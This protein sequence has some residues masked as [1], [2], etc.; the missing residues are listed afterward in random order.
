ME[1]TTSKRGKRKGFG[2]PQYRNGADSTNRR[3][4]GNGD[5]NS[6]HSK[7]RRSHGV[8]GGTQ[9]TNGR[10][11]RSRDR[12]QKWRTR[13]DRHNGS[14]Q[15]E[16]QQLSL[17]TELSVPGPAASPSIPG[18]YFDPDKGKYFKLR[19]GEK[20][21]FLKMMSD[22]AAA[23]ELETKATNPGTPLQASRRQIGIG[24][25]WPDYACGNLV[26]A[27][28]GRGLGLV[29]PLQMQRSAVT[30]CLWQHRTSVKLDC[31]RPT[32]QVTAIA[33]NASRTKLAMVLSK[34]HHKVCSL[35]AGDNILNDVDPDHGIP[36]DDTDPL[37]RTISATTV[38]ESSF[39]QPVTAVRFHP[40]KDHQHAILTLGGR[41]VGGG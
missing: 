4:D 5:S 11:Y 40:T 28:R 2:R 12:K 19:P 9:N 14:P 35:V 16:L 33:I 3:G 21:P 25:C 22:Q 10:S 8:H 38:A 32:Q 36:P 20:D 18:F 29:P 17:S 6:K 13:V 30:A 39:T 27:L 37:H 34:T 31:F 1:A 24:V 23:I 26:R 15:K 41:G 7:K